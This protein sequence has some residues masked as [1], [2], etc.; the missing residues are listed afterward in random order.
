MS[1]DELRAEYLDAERRGETKA[2]PEMVTA[3]ALYRIAAELAEFNG[4]YRMVHGIVLPAPPET[5]EDSK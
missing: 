2:A 3:R 5:E 1:A 4:Y